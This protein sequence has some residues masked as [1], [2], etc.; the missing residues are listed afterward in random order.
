M[1]ACA[2]WQLKVIRTVFTS[3]HHIRS[4]KPTLAL[5]CQLLIKYLN[6]F[7]FY[8][9]LIVSLTASEVA[10]AAKQ[11]FICWRRTEKSRSLN[12]IS[13]EALML[14]FYCLDLITLNHSWR[15]DTTDPPRQHVWVGYNT[16]EEQ[17]QIIC[18]GRVIALMCF[19]SVVPS[20]WSAAAWF[21]QQLDHNSFSSTNEEESTSKLIMMGQLFQW[22][23]FKINSHFLDSSWQP[24]LGL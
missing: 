12:K 2:D 20:G 17:S 13:K 24:L 8:F 1:S 14:F 4:I 9:I 23:L 6:F 16:S 18:G 11:I 7:A 22:G 5:M 3:C 19:L 21:I 15:L 10:K